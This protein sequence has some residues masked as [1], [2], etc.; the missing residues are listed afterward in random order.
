MSRFTAIAIIISLSFFGCKP[1]ECEPPIKNVPQELL[2]FMPEVHFS[3]LSYKNEKDGRVSF[4]YSYYSDELPDS[5]NSCKPRVEYIVLNYVSTSPIHSIS[6]Q[7]DGGEGDYLSMQ[8]E[9]GDQYGNC[10]SPFH[11]KIEDI[12]DKVDTL[13]L[14]GESFVNVFHKTTAPSLCSTE[15]YYS[16]HFG[17]VAFEWNGEWYVLEKDSLQ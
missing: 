9:L 10:F 1:D 14:M 17:I 5:P 16:T 3:K 15:L 12:S 2:D 6:Y 11:V 13:N 4:V 7:V 8:I